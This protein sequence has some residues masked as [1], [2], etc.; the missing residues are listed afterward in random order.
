MT[1]PRLFTFDFFGTIVDWRTG[2]RDDLARLGVTLDDETFDR[3]IDAQAEDEQDD[4]R[5][6]E[7]ITARSLVRVCGLAPDAAAAI[8]ARLGHWPLFADAPQAMAQLQTIAPC[9]ATTNS[10]RAHRAPIEARLGMSLAHWVC[11]EDVR[12]YKPD[13]RVIRAAGVAAGVE[14][15]PTWWHV[16]AYTDYDLETARAL[17]LTT[18][19]VTRPHARAPVPGRVPDVTVADLSELARRAGERGPGAPNAAGRSRRAARRR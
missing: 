17:G 10:D 8:G 11:A 14:P 7:E 5:S 16:S 13:P 1:R 9:A 15:G 12:A 4:Y 2:L 19:L 3:V 18:V 6:Y